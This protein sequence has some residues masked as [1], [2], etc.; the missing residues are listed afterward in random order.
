VPE[1]MRQLLVAAAANLEAHFPATCQQLLQ[2]IW[3]DIVLNAHQVQQQEEQQLRKEERRLSLQKQQE[4][5]KM[6]E[7][8]SG[9][10]SSGSRRWRKRHSHPR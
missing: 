7:D 10:S 3:P 8:G 1:P 4:Q 5:H 2:S 9:K 6:Q